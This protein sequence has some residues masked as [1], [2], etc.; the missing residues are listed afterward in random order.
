MNARITH[1]SQT[2]GRPTTTSSPITP[3]AAVE[4]VFHGSVGHS[5]HSFQGEYAAFS[6][7][8]V[9]KVSD[10]KSWKVNK[11]QQRVSR[12]WLDG[13]AKGPRGSG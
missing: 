7:F 4:R 9:Y 13:G 1:T 11:M 12:G 3:L 2:K 8:R 10:N 5:R 6:Y